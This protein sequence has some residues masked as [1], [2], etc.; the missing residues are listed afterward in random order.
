MVEMILT[1]AL[2][3]RKFRFDVAPGYV[4]EPRRT[5]ELSHLR[6]VEHGR[7]SESDSVLSLLYLAISQAFGIAGPVQ[8]P[9][10]GMLVI[11]QE[12]VLE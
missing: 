7:L 4:P 8:E 6:W 3:Y 1:I 9:H 5:G 10:G 2:L 11:P 12:R